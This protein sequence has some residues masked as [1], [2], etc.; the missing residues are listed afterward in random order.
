MSALTDS[1]SGK[2]CEAQTRSALILAFNFVSTVV[3]INL[4]KKVFSD[5]FGFPAALSNIHYAVSWLCLALLKRFSPSLVPPIPADGPLWKDPD[6]LAMVLLIGSV[7]PLN[8]MS[9]QLNPIAFYQ[10]AKLAVT[11][12]V[13]CIECYSDVGT[14]LDTRRGSPLNIRY[15]LDFKL[16]SARRALCLIL[17][18]VFVIEMRSGDEGIRASLAGLVA[19]A[20]WVPLAAAYKVH[21]GRLR[22]KL[23]NCSTLSLML[24]LF[25]LALV[26]QT[27]LSPLVDP[28]GVL[29][30]PWTASSIAAVLLSG[31][32]AF[33][34]NL[35]GFLV[36]GHLGAIPHVLLGQAK[37]A[38][39]LLAAAVIS[40]SRYTTREL[41]CATGAMGSIIA[42]AVSN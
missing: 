9:L 7:T 21:F 4:N 34:V 40:G 15:V 38:A 16:P 23:G 39:T 22:R 35:S 25:P 13:V 19:V 33:F 10:T 17:V 1:K 8:N 31:L 20:I 32:G 12:V 27:V 28:P 37:S 6:F 42:Y 36:V 18:C 26:V 11:P 3:L 14:V 41:V 5:G 30:H 24:E 2:S 29:D